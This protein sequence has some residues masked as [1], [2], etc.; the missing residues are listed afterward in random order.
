MTNYQKIRHGPV[1]RQIRKFMTPDKITHTLILHQICGIEF[2]LISQKI[3]C[4]EKELWQNKNLSPTAHE[5]IHRNLPDN[6]IAKAEPLENYDVSWYEC[7][8]RVTSVSVVMNAYRRHSVA[9]KNSRSCSTRVVS[10]VN[11]WYWVLI[12]YFTFPR[13]I[14]RRQTWSHHRAQLTNYR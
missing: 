5:Q 6:E 1:V 13:R 4:R 14:I 12:T 9:Q 8:E 7:D 2:S 3:P 11:F 10:A